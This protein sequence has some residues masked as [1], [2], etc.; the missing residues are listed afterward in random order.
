MHAPSESFTSIFLKPSHARPAASQISVIIV[1]AIPSSIL[2]CFD[3]T[4]RDKLNI[5]LD[6]APSNTLVV[7]LREL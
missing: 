6:A 7:V 5:A 2:L 1:F 4:V 3:R